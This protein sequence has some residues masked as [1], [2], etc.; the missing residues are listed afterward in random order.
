MMV[1]QIVQQKVEMLAIKTQADQKE[2]IHPKKTIQEEMTRPITILIEVVEEMMGMINRI[3]TT[4]ESHKIRM[5]RKRKRKKKKML[6]R[7]LQCHVCH[8]LCLVMRN[9]ATRLT[10]CLIMSPSLAV[11]LEWISSTAHL[12]SSK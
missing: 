8:L 11:S 7:H 2:A 12:H 5:K 6:T 3:E 4:R 9:M 10:S 1:T